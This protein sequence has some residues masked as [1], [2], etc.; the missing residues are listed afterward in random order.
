MSANSVQA[1]PTG[2]ATNVAKTSTL[3]AG[4][5]A[6][7]VSALLLAFYMST[8]IKTFVA[9]VIIAIFTASGIWW[10]TQPTK[11]NSEKTAEVSTSTPPKVIASMPAAMSVAPQVALPTAKPAPVSQPVT[12]APAKDG[13]QAELDAVIDDIVT[14]VQAGDMKGMEEKY[15]LPVDP[16][17]LSPRQI[18]M[19]ASGNTPA[20][21]SSIMPPELLQRTAQGFES[22]KTQTPHLNAAGDKATYQATMPAITLPSG[23]NIPESKQT[24]VLQKI[25]GRWYQVSN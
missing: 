25:D 9:V 17:K 20:D 5:G 15:G 2:L 14:M 8:K 16:A 6:S 10:F 23:V 19:R 22:L 11:T 13:V 3:G 12:A 4:S 7:F 18:A 24:F 1:A 21:L